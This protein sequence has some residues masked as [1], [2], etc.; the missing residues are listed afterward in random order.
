MNNNTQ[1]GLNRIKIVMICALLGAFIIC[2]KS[3]LAAG[4]TI[5][6]AVGYYEKSDSF[7]NNS[8]DSVTK[9]A[10]GKAGLGSLYL[11]GNANITSDMNSVKAYTCN[12]DVSIGY[13]YNGGF[14]TSVKE[15]WNIYNADE[16]TIGDI[17]LSKKIAKGVVLIQ[18][19][20][21]AVNWVNAVDPKYDFFAKNKS[22]SDS[23]YTIT[24]ED[25]L[26]GTY[27]R[28]YVAY[29]MK[30][31]T[32]DK[33]T[34]IG[35]KDDNEVKRCVEEYKFFVCYDADPIKIYDMSDRSRE[36]SNNDSVAD[37]F[38]IDKVG[39]N[40][41]I[42]VKRDNVLV[43]STVN[44][45]TSYTTPGVY[46]ITSKS[47]VGTSFETVVTIS[48]GLATSEL[49]PTM[50]SGKDS[51]DYSTSNVDTTVPNISTL[52]I[53]QK[54]GNNIY[55]STKNGFTAYGITGDSVAFYIRVKD[56]DTYA[57]NGWQ[58]EEDTYGKKEKQLIEGA[59]T[60]PIDS[61]TLVIQTSK[62][63]KTW[64]N[65]DSGK[66]S[67]GLYTTDF[68]NNYAGLGD[69]YIYSPDGN[70]VLSGM[71]IRILYAYKTKEVNGKTPKRCVEEYKFY[72]CSNELD[73]VTFPNLSITE[74]K[75]EICGE[76]DE[77][78][79]EMYK[80]SQTLT[81]GSVT[82]SG[83]AIDNS[84]N[85]TVTYTVKKDGV[86][87][88][89][90]SDH[91]FTETGKYEIELKSAVG[92]TKNVTLYVDRMSSRDALK[93][94]F[95][96]GFIQGKR[97][98]SGGDYPVFEGGL[99]NYNIAAVDVNYLPIYG[100]I[101]NV[102]N[103]E[104][105]DISA[106]RNSKVAAIN[107]PGEYVA[108]FCNN[109][110]YD[111]D[112]ISG[113]N[114]VITFR[115]R[116]IEKGNAPG[117]VINKQNLINANKENISGAYP[118]YYGLTY[119]SA[120]KGNITKAY[121]TRKAAVQ[122]A[123]NYEKGMVEIQADGTY[124]YTGSF[125][126]TRKEKYDS[127][128][129]LTDAENYFA[130]QAV[131][132]LYFDLSDEYT[133]LTLNEA[134]ISKYS[135]LRK[136]ELER[137]VTIY[138]DDEQ[139]NAL[140]SIEALPIIN[141]LPYSYLTD[142]NTKKPISG[143][144]DFKFVRD[145][146]GC[147]SDSVIITDCDGKEYSIQYNKGV[148]LQLASQGCPTGKITITES[149]VYGDSASYDAVFYADDDITAKLII[150]YYSKGNRE[151]VTY[152]QDSNDDIKT[153]DLFSLE[154][155]KDELDPYDVVIVEGP[156][157]LYAY[158]EDQL[159]KAVWADEGE[160]TITVVNRIGNKYSVKINVDESDYATISFSGEGTENLDTI[161]ASYEDNKTELPVIEKDG[162]TLIGYEDYQGNLYENVIEKIDFR[163]SVVLSP[164]WRANQ[165]KLT[166]LN[167]DGTEV[168]EMEISYGAEYE[169]PKLDDRDDT[170]FVGWVK[171]EEIYKDKII[172]TEDQDIVLVALYRDKSEHAAENDET[173]V[174]NK[175]S[176][177]IIIFV[178]I[179][180][181]LTAGGVFCF[182]KKKL[183]IDKEV[184]NNNSEEDRDE[185][186]HN[187]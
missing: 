12:G 125:L 174:H 126:V 173:S 171:G 176:G 31:K 145:K 92:V 39:A 146:Y 87:V 78:L 17:S 41:G 156:A 137:S 110:T 185:E 5:V 148:S 141:A 28:V 116:I 124:R 38:V 181:A 49:S 134:T 142:S 136:L 170:A 7:S 82:V 166:L 14:Q 48:N 140:T 37:G 172:I 72:L 114:R 117:P 120:A 73:A 165:Y 139:E 153:V 47:P 180:L 105:I 95:G 67:K 133:Y 61:G 157:G 9:F 42:T 54:A 151:T 135:N 50:Y 162:Y 102:T 62:D 64:E 169:L 71:Y 24:Q 131:Q 132:E 63:G 147:D 96:D 13:T 115:F 179:V 104:K 89:V 122:A 160:Y 69:I 183:N 168:S 30:R 32:G 184:L 18:K 27:F 68:T 154:D 2:G 65:I 108:V 22:G 91:K 56:S 163:G 4:M 178:L 70:D 25:I 75:E 46:T 3:A 36:L 20:L 43:S 90:P 29:S 123:Y 100:Y 167:D 60:G 121:A 52:I 161:I 112:V 101:Q 81:S 129:D 107:D 158:A 97:I 40:V 177:E 85:P 11:N 119:P 182:V 23:L 53:G 15:D 77:I 34:W 66:Y 128:W 16:K 55:K 186:E 44:S 1:Q 149:T 138:A 74:E 45:L 79:T 187:E 57:D 159:D 59:Q 35:K 93:Y 113:D 51:Q 88:G 94:Y 175:K 33:K 109:P 6:N 111:N 26:N 130:E 127:T 58:V 21:D 98:Y 164:V 83:F 10:Y 8:K 150:S 86:S 80:K 106:T 84:L 143:T 152:T 76:D 103:G 99:T 144:S 118:I 19:S 155:I